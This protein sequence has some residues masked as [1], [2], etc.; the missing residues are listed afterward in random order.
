[1][2]ARHDWSE[3]RVRD[4]VSKSVSIPNCLRLLGIDPK[5]EQWKE[6]CEITEKP[7][8]LVRVRGLIFFM[9]HKL[10]IC[11]QLLI[12]KLLLRKK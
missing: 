8:C 9:C 11:S 2:K 6:I 4:A 1:M 10:L 5:K 3:E 12:L 7:P